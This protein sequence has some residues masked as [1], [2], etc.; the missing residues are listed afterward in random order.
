MITMIEQNKRNHSNETVGIK[1]AIVQ[2]PAVNTTYN[3]K[4]NVSAVWCHHFFLTFWML[5]L[6][7]HVWAHTTQIN[8]N[9]RVTTGSRS[10]YVWSPVCV[11]VCMPGPLWWGN[12]LCLE[13]ERSSVALRLSVW[14]D[15]C[16]TH[17]HNAR[18]IGSGHWQHLTT[19]NGFLTSR[20]CMWPS[21][22]IWVLCIPVKVRMFQHVFAQ[23]F[24]LL[25]ACYHHAAPC[26]YFFSTANAQG[27]Q[28]YL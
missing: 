21:Q 14:R 19:W 9:H 2:V 27:L 20:K 8:S 3:S 6:F 23:I 25:R 22:A 15:F 7:W 17:W 1:L 18:Q 16:L 10:L 13:R 12:S 11:C 26:R 24:V 5:C 4:P 28:L